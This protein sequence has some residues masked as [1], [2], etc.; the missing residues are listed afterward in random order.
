MKA[1]KDLNVLYAAIFA[2]ALLSATGQAQDVPHVVIGDT[3]ISV[4][5]LE[6]VAGGSLIHSENLALDVYPNGDVA[7]AISL[8]RELW[9][10]VGCHGAM[11]SIKLSE[12]AIRPAVLIEP[13]GNLH[14][15]YVQ[16]HP[17]RLVYLSTSDA[18]INGD[19]NAWI[20]DDDFP[21]PFRTKL[22]SRTP[23]DWLYGMAL[24][25]GE[26]AIGSYKHED[27]DGSQCYLAERQIDTLTWRSVD[28]YDPRCAMIRDFPESDVELKKPEGRI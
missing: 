24:I 8:G 25:D 17:R 10:F 26:I 3:K 20:S 22:I 2:V 18:G 12:S 6:R 5:S 15:S 11:K 21:S 27:S 1:V 9:L 7:L 28:H 14:V 19:P 23:V 13:D 16:W 4:N